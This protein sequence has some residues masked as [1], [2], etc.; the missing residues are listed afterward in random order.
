MLT[1]PFCFITSAKPV[2][3]S[4]SEM[5]PGSSLIPNAD[6]CCK[7]WSFKLI[8]GVT[9]TDSVGATALITGAVTEAD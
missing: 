7:S 6:H 9:A 3:R 2:A 1:M 8:V 5:P 4:A